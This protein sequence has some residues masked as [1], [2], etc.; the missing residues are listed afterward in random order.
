MVHADLPH[1]IVEGDYGS[2]NVQRRIE[3]IHNIIT[4]RVRSE[5]VVNGRSF[6]VAYR[7]TGLRSQA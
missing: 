5:G 2:R 4:K 6:L 3:G 1:E 7:A